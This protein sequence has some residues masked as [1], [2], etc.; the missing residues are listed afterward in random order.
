MP[1]DPDAR[2]SRLLNWLSR[3][4]APTTR[5]IWACGK[6]TWVKGIPGSV[7]TQ[8]VQ[9]RFRISVRSAVGFVA[10]LALTTTGCSSASL[11]APPS[12]VRQ[13]LSCSLLSTNQAERVVGRRVAVYTVPSECDYLL[14]R[15]T[16]LSV[17]AAPVNKAAYSLADLIN[18]YGGDPGS[19]V[20]QVAGETALWIT[21]PSDVGGGGRL[22]AVDHNDLIEVTMTSG[23]PDPKATAVRAMTAIIH[24]RASHV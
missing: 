8:K 6:T 19:S 4:P 1:S 7:D 21:Y 15:G 14:K 9:S 18:R 16:Y 12:P 23:G 22:Q 5:H 20:F 13:N 17:S 10:I 11:S 3:W 2:V 24:A